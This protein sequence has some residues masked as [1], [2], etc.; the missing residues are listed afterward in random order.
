MTASG[1]ALTSVWFIVP[2]VLAW[3]IS[4]YWFGKDVDQAMK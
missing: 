1:I 4:L 3:L 2:A